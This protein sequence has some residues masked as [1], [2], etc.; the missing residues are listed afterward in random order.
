MHVNPAL[1]HG[2]PRAQRDFLHLHDTGLTFF[3]FAGFGIMRG[4]SW[5]F[6]SLYPKS[7][8][9]GKF[10]SLECE[11]QQSHQLVRH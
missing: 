1:W 6:S 3:G 7:V 4:T 8:G 9:Q 2:H 11:A 10:L 5:S